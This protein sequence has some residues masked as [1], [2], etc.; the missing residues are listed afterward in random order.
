MTEPDS[1]HLEIESFNLSDLNVA[2]MDVRLEL[3]SLIPSSIII[4]DEN[5]CPD[6]YGCG[7]NTCPHDNCGVFCAADCSRVTCGHNTGCLVD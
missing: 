2:A 6:Y 3:T 1:E 7:V 5:A 4:C